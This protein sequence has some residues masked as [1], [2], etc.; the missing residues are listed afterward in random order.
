MSRWR[1]ARGQVRAWYWDSQ[2]AYK[3]W[4]IARM[5]KRDPEY[6]KRCKEMCKRIE[7]MAEKW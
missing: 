2:F 7:K 3:E 4:R 1:C 5:I 6:R